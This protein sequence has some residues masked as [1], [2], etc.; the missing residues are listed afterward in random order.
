MCALVTC[1]VALDF[2][3]GSFR[4]RQSRVFLRDGVVYRAL[5]SAALQEFQFVAGCEFFNS[6][7]TEGRVV[8][9][10][11]VEP[12]EAD[13]G[14]EL[15]WA[16]ALRHERIPFVSYP[17]EW[18]FGMLR[19]SARL[20][21]DL[22]E[23]ALLEGAILKDATPYNVQFQGSQPV[24]ID[25]G[26][27][28]RH[29]PNEA[30]VGY[31]QFC[32][33]H[34]YP[35]MLQ[36]YRGVDFQPWLRGRIDGIPPGQFSRLLSLRDWFR[37]GV[38]T[39]VVLHATLERK[40]AGGDRS[41]T[42]DLNRSGFHKD[43]ILANV[44][45][46]KGIVDGLSWSESRSDW[47]EYDA[48]SDPV[49]NDGAAKEEFVQQVLKTRKWGQV[50]DLGCNLG[51]YSRIAAKHADHV[52][53]MDQDHW[54]VEKLFRSLQEEQ[55]H[56]ILPL[57]MNLSDASPGLGWN[58][59]ERRRLESRGTPDLV[60]CLAFLHHLVIREN[61]RI[62]DVLDWLARLRGRLAIEFVDR[63]DPQ[64]VSL[65]RNRSDACEDYSLAHFEQCLNERF[66]VHRRHD[67]PSGTRTIFDA[68][69][70]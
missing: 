69:P 32:Q 17:Y 28:V 10:L 13:E 8:P 66:E 64:V 70:R 29:R 36:A 60:L 12:G 3:P 4:D 1:P 58:G 44:R 2:E 5:S 31:R 25:V 9:T 49:R 23:A 30:W 48:T 52:V 21:L 40:A 37:R 7:M 43:L 26:S 68:V 57:A 22:L 46:L 45:K 33:M 55:E 27:F 20:H 16:G 6:A 65:L 39:H 15:L 34:L 56:R 59:R 19:E 14:L 18:S 51:R 42:H 61:L 63:S 67:L 35:L 41:V 50:W 53:A 24:F 38:L 47:S 11:A 54:T 62:P